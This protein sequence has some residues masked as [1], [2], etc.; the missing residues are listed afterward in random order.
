MLRFFKSLFNRQSFSVG[1]SVGW[2]AWLAGAALQIA[3]AVPVALWYAFQRPSETD[4]AALRQKFDTLLELTSP[5]A[6]VALILVLNWIGKSVLRKRDL[7]VP[8][9]FIG[10]AIF[11]RVLILS[12]GLGLTDWMLIL[13]PVVFWIRIPGADTVALL[14]AL[15]ALFTITLCSHGWATLRTSRLPI[16][17][18]SL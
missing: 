7:P 6:L 10:W 9:R 16:M 12:L 11:W 17:D 4:P 3:C 5:L 1:W 13:L 8:A 14:V 15:I 2:R 18:R